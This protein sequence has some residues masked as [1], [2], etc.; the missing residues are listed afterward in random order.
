MDS[1]SS[2]VGLSS[3]LFLALYDSD[4][5]NLLDI[6]LNKFLWSYKFILCKAKSYSLRDRSSSW[7]L[8]LGGS[9]TRGFLGTYTCSEGL[10]FELFSEVTRLSR[11]YSYVYS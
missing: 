11:V 1:I 2:F 4:F 7:M 9:I 6:V 5:Y 3:N 8:T 10:S